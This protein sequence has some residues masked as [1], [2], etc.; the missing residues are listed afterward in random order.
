[1][2]VIDRHRLVNWGYLTSDVMLRSYV[3]ELRD[4][5]EPVRLPFP[6]ADFSSQP[7]LR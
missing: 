3:P 7:P 5:P 2:P 6:N 1:M 4:E